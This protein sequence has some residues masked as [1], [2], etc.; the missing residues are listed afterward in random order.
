LE[1]VVAAAAAWFNK[2]AVMISNADDHQ[3][4]VYAASWILIGSRAGFQGQHQIETAGTILAPATNGALWTDD[5]SSLLKI[6]K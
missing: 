3:K 6:L 1:P 4:G 2:E 5:Y